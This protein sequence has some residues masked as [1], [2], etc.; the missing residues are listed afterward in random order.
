MDSV[1]VNSRSVFRRRDFNDWRRIELH[2]VADVV[3]HLFGLYTLPA[4][5]CL[6][7]RQHTPDSK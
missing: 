5:C 2:E 7:Q 1:F 4:G 6:K 3:L